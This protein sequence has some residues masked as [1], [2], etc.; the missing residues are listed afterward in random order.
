[1]TDGRSGPSVVRGA[2]ALAGGMVLAA[3]FG[4]LFQS[5]LSY[6]FGAGAETDAFFMSVS[7]FMLLSKFLMLGQAK[8]IALPLM[9][10]LE[11]VDARGAARL[12]GGTLKLLVVGLAAVSLIAAL[13]A[14][15]LVRVFAPGFDGEQAQLT[16]LLL[17][18]R[19]PALVFAGFVT[20]ARVALETR[21]RFGTAVLVGKVVPA[22]L[23]FVFLLW[24]GS[25]ARISD[26]AWIGMVAPAGGA[27][28]LL[29]LSPG[30]L[31][32]GV[33]A[34]WKHAEIRRAVRGWLSFSQS[35]GASFLGEW[36]FRIGASLL[37]VGVFSAVLYG[38]M[39]HDV[40]HGAINDPA[41]TVT[42]PQAARAA[43]R[44]GPRALGNLLRKRVTSLVLLTAPIAALLIIL[45]PWI[46]AILFGRGRFLEDG[47]LGPTALALSIY[48]V[49]FLLQ[50]MNQILFTGAYALG[51][52]HLVNRV[53]VIGHLVRA[54]AVVPLVLGF[55][56]T[57]LVGAQAGMNLLVLVLVV[58]MWPAELGVGWRSVTRRA[59]SGV[60]GVSGTTNAAE[61]AS[62]FWKPVRRTLTASALSALLVVQGLLLAGDP[63]THGLL[64]RVG[65]CVAAAVG[66]MGLYAVLGS[67][68]GLPIVAALRGALGGLRAPGM[69]PADPQEDA[70]TPE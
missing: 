1:M 55:G 46:V 34:A 68:M 27:A 18:I 69:D 52:S 30:L 66:F 21:A 50:G 51:S 47:M 7:I 43:E 38:K 63:L 36:A 57:G 54:I 17:R 37:P 5:L 42:L 35:T 3:V 59:R 48:A 53:N 20:V 28:L 31:I 32:G 56:L 65:V 67:V 49:G 4:L 23:T 64:A 15:L 19:M 9:T 2:G 22:A 33:P 14:P 40:A 8:S 61:E 10:R 26:V 29:L 44:G 41:T 45:A 60:A 70:S 11:S 58:S 62:P 16:A 13:A 6:L 12:F 24:V 25:D 39:V